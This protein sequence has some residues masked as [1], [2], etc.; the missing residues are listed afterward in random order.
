MNDDKIIEKCNET[1]EIYSPLASRLG[2][3]SIKFEL[4]DLALRYLDPEAFRELI[5]NV[6]EKKDARQENLD[7]VIEEIKDALKDL[8]IEYDIKGRQKH[9]YSIYKKMQ[10]QH[11]QLDEIFDLIGVRIRRQI[12]RASCRERV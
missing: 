4:E 1:L 2:I 11:K 10:Y 9:L 5:E 12:G 8:H 6:S 7:H 3:Y